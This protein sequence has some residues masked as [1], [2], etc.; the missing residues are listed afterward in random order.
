MN[1]YLKNSGKRQRLHEKGAK[2][3]KLE[4]TAPIGRKTEFR[5]HSQK[6]GK[7]PPRRD[8]DFSGERARRTEEKLETERT[9]N[10]L[11]MEI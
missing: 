2:C 10:H 3:C 9:A 6:C 11:K 5:P 7:S 1:S 4:T 8:K